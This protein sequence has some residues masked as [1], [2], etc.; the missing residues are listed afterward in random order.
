VLEGVSWPLGPTGK[1][2]LA[3]EKSWTTLGYAIKT[4]HVSL[5]FLF[6]TNNYNIDICRYCQTAERNVS[7]EKSSTVVAA[8]A[9]F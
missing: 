4:G 2:F 7:S 8:I 9:T 1:L 5:S 6:C 3:W